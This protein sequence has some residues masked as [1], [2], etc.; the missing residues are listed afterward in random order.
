MKASDYI[1]DCLADLGVTHVYEVVGGM[2]T[3]ILD[4][5]GTKAKVKIVSVHHEQAAGFAAEGHARITGTP[6]VAMATSGPGA[7]N[8]I[9]AI[10]SC[11]FDSV[12]AVFITGQVNSYERK[13]TLAIRQLGFQETDIVSMVKPITKMAKEVSH[14]DQL[15]SALQDAFRI[16]TEGRPGPVLL[17]ITMDVQRNQIEQAPVFRS[18]KPSNDE[19]RSIE[20]NSVFELLSKAERPLVLLGG[21]AAHVDQDE[22]L[23]ALEKIG[24]PCVA[25]LMA[26]HLVP[27]QHPLHAGFI[28]SYG[29]RW[30]NIAISKSDLMIVL[31][32]RLD[33]RQT[34]ADVEGFRA[35]KKIIHVDVDPSE[36]NNRVK[37]CLPIEATV[38]QFCS[39]VNKS[40]FKNPSWPNWLASIDEQRKKYPDELELRTVKGINPNILLKKVSEHAGAAKAYVTDVGQHQMWAA[41]SIRFKRGQK[42][43]TSGGMGAMGFGLP[44]AIGAAIACQKPVV[45]IAGDGGF[46]LNI[47]EL[48]TI[49]RNQLPIKIILIN[50]HC[51]GMVRQFQES[52]FESRF[53]S[54]VIGYSA[55]DFVKIS[56]AYQ[57]KSQTVSD[58]NQLDKALAEVFADEKSPY[59]LEV[60][61]PATTNV[62]PKIAF[63]RPISEMEPDFTP[64]GFES[65]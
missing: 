1:A 59:L 4:S 2:I 42:F 52:Y 5:I 25:S 33:I 20:L 24:A 31:G 28:G 62:Y 7:T 49:R 40:A 50:N 6:S 38:Q 41:Q 34:G 19:T 54:T 48:E 35:D 64:T 18:P 60:Q 9:T 11:Y 26:V 46:Q 47:Q 36:M 61:I 29:N 32:S 44:A 23:R 45:L 14:V 27:S 21:G 43:L 22:L 13:G 53:Q 51:H 15:P 63:G 58:L 8:L 3:H 65:T 39:S 30:A 57:I 17:D 55:P 37:D 12:P 10:G 16:A 56:N